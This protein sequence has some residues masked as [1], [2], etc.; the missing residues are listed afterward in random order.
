MGVP[1]LV[2]YLQAMVVGECS[3]S[4]SDRRSV[5]FRVVLDFVLKVTY[6]AN[7]V[8]MFDYPWGLPSA[9]GFG[10]VDPLDIQVDGPCMV[11]ICILGI[12]HACHERVSW[13]IWCLELLEN[14]S[15][16]Y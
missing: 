10:M 9:G 16:M 13:P 12:P 2:V 3:V 1:V 15:P 4:N 6:V 11:G 5:I 14:A 7:S 8:S